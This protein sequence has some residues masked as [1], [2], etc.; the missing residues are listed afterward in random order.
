MQRVHEPLRSAICGPQVSGSVS[1]ARRKTNLE[2]FGFPLREEFP[3]IVGP[4]NVFDARVFL[5]QAVLDLERRFGGSE[6]YLHRRAHA[7]ACARFN[8]RRT[9]R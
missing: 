4:F 3:R 1:E 8:Q 6:D 2:A 7:S 5:S 9:A